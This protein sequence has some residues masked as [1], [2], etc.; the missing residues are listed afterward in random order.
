[1]LHAK[2]LGLNFFMSHLT[3][4]GVL[5]LDCLEAI[6]FAGFGNLLNGCRLYIFF[7]K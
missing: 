4:S 7:P 5:G 3:L 1:M 6:G 2:Q